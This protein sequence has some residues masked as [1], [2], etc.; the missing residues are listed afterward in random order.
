MDALQALGR[1]FDPDY[2]QNTLFY[3][4]FSP[5]GLIMFFFILS[6]RLRTFV[7]VYV[8]R[9]VRFEKSKLELALI[10]NLS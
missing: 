10:L 3:V 5:T 2:L 7:Q 6:H 8:L 9:E 1:R 4:F